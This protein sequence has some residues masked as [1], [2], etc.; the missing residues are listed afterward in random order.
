MNPNVIMIDNRRIIKTDVIELQQHAIY[1]RKHKL[2]HGYHCYHDDDGAR[3]LHV[4]HVP[5]TTFVAHQRLVSELPPA[6][7]PAR[8]RWWQQGGQAQP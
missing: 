4:L 3:V 2:A 1:R 6:V 5:G 8:R 7:Q